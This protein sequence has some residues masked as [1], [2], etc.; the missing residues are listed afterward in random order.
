MCA[1]YR[2]HG[3]KSRRALLG[4]RVGVRLCLYTHLLIVLSNVLLLLL[5]GKYYLIHEGT[6]TD[7]V[8]ELRIHNSGQRQRDG[9]PFSHRP[10]RLNGG[11]VVV[12]VC[13]CVATWLYAVTLACRSH[14]GLTHSHKH[15]A[16]TIHSH[17]H[18]KLHHRAIR[19]GFYCSVKC[20]FLHWPAH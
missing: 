19:F 8:N 17:M 15:Q 6:V 13:V 16:L 18:F 7:G 10:D 1:T 12:C 3:S 5:L 4:L 14:T 11:G 9:A 20:T 2:P